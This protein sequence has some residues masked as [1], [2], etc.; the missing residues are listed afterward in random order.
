MFFRFAVEN[1]DML[2]DEKDVSSWVVDRS[3]ELPEKHLITNIFLKG[4][5]GEKDVLIWQPTRKLAGWHRAPMHCGNRKVC[6][7]ARSG[8]QGARPRT[9]RIHYQR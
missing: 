5:F 7:P 8:A 1:S 9:A 2:V 6:P 3:G 4:L